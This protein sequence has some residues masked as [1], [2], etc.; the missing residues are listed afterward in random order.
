ME[1]LRATGDWLW[2]NLVARLRLMVEKV[3]FRR[4]LFLAALFV[5][6]IAFAQLVSI[7]LAF[8]WAIDTA[9]YFEIAS[10]MIAFAIAGH[11]WRAIGSAARRISIVVHRSPSIVRRLTSRQRRNLAALR[12]RL[13]KGPS[14]RSE[15]EAAI[16]NSAAFVA[17]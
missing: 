4:V 8:V 9:F 7:D 15:D 12:R 3:R 17:A 16:C 6:T 11:A 2:F 1:W 14:D 5:A 10:V 13:A